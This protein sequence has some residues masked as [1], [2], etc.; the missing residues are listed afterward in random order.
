LICL[1]ETRPPRWNAHEAV[2]NVLA[3]KPADGSGILPLAIP[4][5]KD[6]EAR[7]AAADVVASIAEQLKGTLPDDAVTPLVA[8]LL[9]H[10]C[11]TGCQTE[12]AIRAFPAATLA[13][14]IREAP[15]IIH[16]KANIAAI[17]RRHTRRS[18]QSAAVL[19]GKL[20][21]DVP[22]RVILWAEGQY[23]LEEATDPRHLQ[24]DSIALG[25]CV[26]TTH[27]SAALAEKGLEP[28]DP[29]A[30]HYLHYWVKLKRARRA[31]SRSPTTPN[32]SPRSDTTSPTK[33]LSRFK[34]N[35]TRAR[36]QATRLTSP[37][38]AAL[39]TPSKAL[40]R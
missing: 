5:T 26:G 20:S 35:G 7:A 31:S 18:Q 23:R 32:R 22:D 28:T 11:K 21:A 8:K 15:E 1:P 33:P 30:I 13:D 39:S 27:S 2:A 3:G 14:A 29:E 6:P 25:H 9:S 4:F 38:C 37:P 36:S 34:T 24:Q 40:S 19:K 10:F 17:L 16:A 12:V